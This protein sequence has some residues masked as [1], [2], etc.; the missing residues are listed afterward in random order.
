MAKL[1]EKGEYKQP[2]AVPVPNTSGYPNKV[3]NTQTQRIRGTKNTS[4]GYGHST[5]MG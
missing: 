4:R 5:K 3:A 2:K 1:S